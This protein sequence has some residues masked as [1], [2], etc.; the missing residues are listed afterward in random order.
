MPSYIDQGIFKG[1]VIK[2]WQG[3]LKKESGSMDIARGIT[4]WHPSQEENG[5]RRNEDAGVSERGQ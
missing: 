3:T 4:G 1:H 5:K 2:E